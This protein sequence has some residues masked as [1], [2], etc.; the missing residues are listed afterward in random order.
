[1]ASQRIVE[2]TTSHNLSVIPLFVL[3]GSQINRARISGDLFEFS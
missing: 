1:M 3:M 2:V